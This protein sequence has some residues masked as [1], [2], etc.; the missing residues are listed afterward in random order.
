[1]VG[2]RGVELQKDSYSLLKIHKIGTTKS[3]KKLWKK[4]ASES[5]VM[6]S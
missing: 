4:N 3:D 6:A 2:R 1:M 5:T